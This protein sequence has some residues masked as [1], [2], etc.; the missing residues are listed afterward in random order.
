M[1]FSGLGIKHGN[2]AKGPVFW[3]RASSKTNNV[4]D[5]RGKLVGYWSWVPCPVREC[6]VHSAKASCLCKQKNGE[7]RID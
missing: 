5:V 1:W 4:M 6:K 2:G 3:T 7:R